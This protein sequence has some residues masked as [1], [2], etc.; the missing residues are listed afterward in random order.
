M[1]LREWI[2]KLRRREDADALERAQSE[3]TETV[4][5]RA[6]ASDDVEGRAADVAAEEHGGEPPEEG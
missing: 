4:D 1:G 3:R 2:D 5:E 6:A